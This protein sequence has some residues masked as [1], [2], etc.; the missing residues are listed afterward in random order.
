MYKCAECQAIMPMALTGIPM[1]VC[2]VCRILWIVTE[3]P[4][5][6][7]LKAKLSRRLETTPYADCDIRMLPQRHA[8]S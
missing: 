3:T 8:V 4:I 7:P 1:Y 6:D 2:R 5:S